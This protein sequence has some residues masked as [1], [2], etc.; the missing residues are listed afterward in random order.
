MFLFGTCIFIAFCSGLVVILVLLLGQLD[1][2]GNYWVP[3]VSLVV[4]PLAIWS[5]HKIEKL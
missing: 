4:C 1:I 2:P 3:L 5:A